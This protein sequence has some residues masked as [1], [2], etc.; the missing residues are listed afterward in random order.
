MEA[1][2]LHH[3]FAQIHP[4]QDGNGRVARSLASLILIKGGFFPLVVHRDNWEKYIDTLEAAD[5]DDPSPLVK[6]FARLQKRDL[7][8]AIVRAADIKP[9]ASVDEA[10][11]VTRE[12]LVHLGKL[13]PP[14]HQ[15]A[16]VNA[17]QLS[18]V[19]AN[20][21][22]AV[23]TRL[24]DDIARAN[25]QFS[26]EVATLGAPPTEELRVLAKELKYDPNP[27]EYFQGPLLIL[28]SN[29]ASSN[30]TVCFHTVGAAFRGLIAVVAYF[31]LG[32]NP[33]IPLSD[34]I[35]RIDY[36]EPYKELEQRYVKWLDACLIQGLAEWRKTLV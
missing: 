36:K 3:A 27:V 8:R 21:L 17:I 14:Q 2:W 30:I 23:A 35:L 25:S 22:S 16:E 15:K 12:L 7:T 24:A 1:A 29:S 34:D 20:R 31:Q 26:F 32:A 4:F 6:L 33:P 5:A 13:V 10:L 18:T 9:V 11:A 19:T 28:D